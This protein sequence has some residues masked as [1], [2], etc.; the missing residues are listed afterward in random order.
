MTG[1]TGAVNGDAV[2]L[3]TTLGTNAGNTIYKVTDVAVY[4]ATITGA[5]TAITAAGTLVATAPA[6]TAFRGI[7]FAPIS[8]DLTIGLSAPTSATLNQ[9]INYSL[10]VSNKGNSSA[11]GIA[12][13]FA[14]P[15]SASATYNSTGDA[16]GFTGSESGG[17]VTFSGGALAAGAS[18]TLTVNVT[19]TVTGALMSGTAL[20]DPSNTIAENNE[21]NNSAAAVTTAIGSDNLPPIAPSIANQVATVGTA[22]SFTVPAF[23]DPE[24]QTLSYAITGLSNGLSADNI[25]RIISGTLRQRA[26]RQ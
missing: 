1:L 18:T 26:Y 21:T 11:S 20:V 17:I 19:P 15:A 8:P 4:N 3:Y 25:T 23:T 6:N 9:P 13:Q 24:S 16:G 22:F 14:L 5:T 12:V 7:A 2:D 10:V